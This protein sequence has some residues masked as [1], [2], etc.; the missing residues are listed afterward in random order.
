MQFYISQELF[1]LFQSKTY[2][3]DEYSCFNRLKTLYDLKINK[4][5]TN[6]IRSIG[7]SSILGLLMRTNCHPFDLTLMINDSFYFRSKSFSGFLCMVKCYWPSRS[8]RPRLDFSYSR[9]LSSI[10]NMISRDLN[11]YI[12]FNIFIRMEIEI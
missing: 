6:L 8:I 1:K 10:F 11:L 9:F 7:S 4:C 2:I 12:N 3:T 5:F